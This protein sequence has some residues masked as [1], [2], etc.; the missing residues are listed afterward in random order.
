[1][2][3]RPGTVGFGCTGE[4]TFE[5]TSH[6]IRRSVPHDERPAASRRNVFTVPILHGRMATTVDTPDADEACAYCESR[7]F[8]H[9]PICVHDCD[10][11]C[12]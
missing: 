1:V 4:R 10:D 6:R 5:G 9:E 12:C 2:V 7:I 3:S 11:D 8:A